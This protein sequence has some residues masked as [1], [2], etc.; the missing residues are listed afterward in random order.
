MPGRDPE[1]WK[2]DKVGN[3]LFR[4]HTSCS[5]QS[6]CHQYDHIIARAKGGQTVL[7]NCQIL[8]TV[9]NNKKSDQDCLDVDE[10]KALSM[11]DQR[12]P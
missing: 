7:E 2:K 11:G 3:V 10:L 6:T 12:L 1:R 9:L 8:Q 4:K 5:Y